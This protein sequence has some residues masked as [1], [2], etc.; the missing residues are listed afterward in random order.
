MPY[1]LFRYDPEDEFEL[2]SELTLLKTRLE[3]K[4]KRVIRISLADCLFTALKSVSPLEDWFEAE[5]AERV[6]NLIQTISNVL[7]SHTPLVDLVAD[8]MPADPDPKSDVVLINRTGALFP[9]YRTFSLLEQLKGR[10]VAPTVCGRG[11]ALRFDVKADLVIV[12]DADMEYDPADHDAV[13]R[14]ILDGVVLMR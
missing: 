14:P 10:V 5:R 13:L 3:Q 1:A 4:S 2:R 9:V 11:S 12:Q 8:Q 6:E 7:E